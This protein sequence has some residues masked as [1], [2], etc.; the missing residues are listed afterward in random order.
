MKSVIKSLVA[1]VVLAGLANA[2]DRLTG[3]P[4]IYAGQSKA[5]RTHDYGYGYLYRGTTDRGE[6][7]AIEIWHTGTCQVAGKDAPYAAVHFWMGKLGGRDEHYYM[8]VPV[9]APW[10]NGQFALDK[11]VAR[12]QS[13]KYYPRGSRDIQIQFNGPLGTPKSYFYRCKGFS[14]TCIIGNGK[15]QPISGC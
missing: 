7:C 4:G 2:E 6:D 11:L 15:P 12:P 1:V 10:E 3:L 14:A 5:A 8:D 9:Y 13:F